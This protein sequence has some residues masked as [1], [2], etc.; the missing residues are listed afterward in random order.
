MLGMLAQPTSLVICVALNETTLDRYEGSLAVLLDDLRTL[1]GDTRSIGLMMP[2]HGTTG[3]TSRMASLGCD[4]YVNTCE[5]ATCAL[6]AAHR[7]EMERPE[8]GLEGR[9]T[10]SEGLYDL[11]LEDETS[12]IQILPGNTRITESWSMDPYL[13]AGRTRKRQA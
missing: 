9:E 10:S 5:E 12:P 3:L 13:V 7:R 4:I 6:G 1:P 11:V 8:R 2:V